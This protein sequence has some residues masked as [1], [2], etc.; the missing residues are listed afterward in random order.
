LIRNREKRLRQERDKVKEQSNVLILQT[1]ELTKTK[2]Y[3]HEALTK[4]D[5]AR[6]E[7]EKTK[8]ELEKANLELK[9]KLDEI[10][11]YGKVTIGREVRMAE[12]KEKIKK[13]E[14]TVKDLQDQI[15]NKE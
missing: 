14:D 13:L 7:M 6:M 9:S 2:D 11:K 10:E 4:S 12:L 8:T 3:L 1:Q 15:T 5:K